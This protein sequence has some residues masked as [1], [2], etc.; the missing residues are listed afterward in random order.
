MSMLD[1]ITSKIDTVDNKQRKKTLMMGILT[2]HILLL[3]LKG[4]LYHNATFFST[5]ILQSMDNASTEIQ[6]M[7]RIRLM[8]SHNAKDLKTNY[9][10]VLIYFFSSTTF[11]SVRIKLFI[12]E[13]IRSIYLFGFIPR[14][15]TS[16]ECLFQSVRIENSILNYY[17]NFIAIIKVNEILFASVSSF[18]SFIVLALSNIDLIKKITNSLNQIK[19]KKSKADS[20]SGSAPDFQFN[21]RLDTNIRAHY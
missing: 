17:N 18:I 9:E 7:I 19:A 5:I 2:E 12:V 13:V 1:N 3:I 6:K 20:V 10:K 14:N 16:V 4:K 11:S 21:L 8:L 15:A